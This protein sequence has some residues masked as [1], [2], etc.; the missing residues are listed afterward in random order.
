[1]PQPDELATLA[2]CSYQEATFLRSVLESEGIS[3]FLPEQYSWNFV[4]AGSGFVELQVYRS[5]M[6]R[7]RELVSALR[8]A[9]G[10]A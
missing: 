6:E 2:D 9:S 4:L 7:A 5:D 3:V 10:S 8:N 1:M